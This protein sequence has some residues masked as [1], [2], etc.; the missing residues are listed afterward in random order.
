MRY[1]QPELVDRLAAAYVLGTMPSRV[2]RRFERLHRD[3]SDVQ[4]AVAQWEQRLGQLGQAVPP[5]APSP[6]VWQAIEARTRPHRQDGRAGR[7]GARWWWPAGLGLGGVLAGAALTVTLLLSAPSLLFTPDQV[8]M[9]AGQ[10]LPQSYVGLLTDAQGNGKL[11]ASSLRHGRTMT[12]KVIGPIEA[13]A[14]G[15]LVL[16]AVP[17]A[18]AP[19]VLGDV[20]PA[21]SATSLLPDT[22]EKLLSKVG[23]L[24]VTVETTPAPTAPSGPSVYAGNCAKLW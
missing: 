23:K 5:V 17:A 21:G 10:K 14:Q 16:W 20:P 1:A 3:R 22:S 8:A 13:P 12:I 6:R 18:G 15:R 4:L 9:R 11:L 19:F 24:M 2:R 7:A